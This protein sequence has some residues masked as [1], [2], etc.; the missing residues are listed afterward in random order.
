MKSPIFLICSER[1]GS[2]LM[3]VILGSHKNISAPAPPHLMKTF[4]PLVQ[5]YGNLNDDAHFQSLADDIAVNLKIQ[6]GDWHIE[7]SGEAFAARAESR[8]LAGLLDAVYSLESE[9]RGT[10][11]YFIKDN[12][13]VHWT[14]EILASFPDA[15]FLY[16]V[17]DPRDAALSWLKSDHHPGGVAHA[18]RIWADEQ[19][20]ALRAYALLHES[21][22]IQLLHYEDLVSDPEGSIRRMCAFIGEE[23]DEAMLEFHKTK[24]AETSA[25]WNTG[26]KNLVNPMMS[27]NF[28]KYRSGLSSRQIRTIEGIARREMQMLGYPFEF[29]PRRKRGIQWEDIPKAFNALKTF[30]S[31]VFSRRTGKEGIGKYVGRIRNLRAIQ[32]ERRSTPASVWKSPRALAPQDVE[33]HDESR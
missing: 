22:K 5:T 12:G 32:Q 29:A 17:R 9:V 25:R 2:N 14:F 10:P 24:E 1:S 8:S 6:Y 31:L 30:T 28:G 13:V 4:F 20:K 19:Q 21:D 11:R 27:S 7:P 3:R 23:F 33:S 18:T 16:V 26:W 15:K